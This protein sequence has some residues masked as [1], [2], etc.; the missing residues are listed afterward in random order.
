MVDSPA[1]RLDLLDS[2]EPSQ[3]VDLC[4]RV[5][6]V[7]L[8]TRKVKELGA[9]VDLFPKPFL[10]SLFGF[11]ECLVLS[12]IIQVSKHSHDIGHSVILEE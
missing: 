8:L 3:V 9:I 7:S 6:T 11:S 4:L 2:D 10:H 5:H 1:Q 12:K